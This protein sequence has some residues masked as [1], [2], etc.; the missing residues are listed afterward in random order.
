MTSTYVL[1]NKFD[2]SDGYGFC[3]LYDI[4]NGYVWEL[5]KASSSYS[6]RT[7]N[8]LKQLGKYL[9]GKIKGISDNVT[10]KYPEYAIPDGTFPC[11]AY[12][13]TYT[14]KYWDE[15]N[16]I[17][18]YKY[19]PS[20]NS[21]KEPEKSLAVAP[22]PAPMFDVYGQT[23]SAKDAAAIAASASICAMGFAMFA[24]K[25]RLDYLH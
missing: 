9:L 4:E 7:E 21:K 22:A 13:K 8:A 3:D 5:K 10:L 2:R 20:D 25:L 24:P 14:V 17:L 11:E 23:R 18:R 1:Y 15:G 6:C 12:G 19:E 16:G